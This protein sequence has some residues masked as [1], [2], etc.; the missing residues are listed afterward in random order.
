MKKNLKLDVQPEAIE[1]WREKL[2]P[3]YKDNPRWAEIAEEKV[4][5]IL[6]KAVNGWK[7]APLT[8]EKRINILSPFRNKR[9]RNLRPDAEH[10]PVVKNKRQQEYL[11][12]LQAD[13]THG[14]IFKSLTGREK[15]FINAR[16]KIYKGEF[17]MN[18]SADETM[19]IKVLLEELI[20]NRVGKALAACKTVDDIEMINMLT[21]AMTES[22]KRLKETL[23]SLGITREQRKKVETAPD[24]NIAQLTLLLEKKMK[25]L[26]EIE[27]EDRQEEEYYISERSSRPPINIVTKD[28][29]RAVM[30]SEEVGVD[31]KRLSAFNEKRKIR[32]E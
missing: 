3:I 31:D 12:A 15:R 17:E 2:L 24:G 14:D 7:N 1:K 27:A 11:D 9:M 22:S 10:I 6:K 23:Q 19:L 32:T 30:E 28:E 4:A 8:F 18:R 29:I 21:K 13:D 16:E 25:K 20:Q 26:K 5:K